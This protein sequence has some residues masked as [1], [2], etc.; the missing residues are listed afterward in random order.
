MRRATPQRRR[1]TIGRLGIGVV[2][3]V[4]TVDD[5]NFNQYSY[6]AHSDAATELGA[7][8]SAAWSSEDAAEYASLIQ[9]LRRRRTTTSSSPLASTWPTT[10]S[11][12][13]RP[14]RT[15]GSSASTRRRS[16]STRPAHRTRLRLR[17]RC[18]RLCIPNFVGIQYAGGP[19][20]LS[21]RHRRRDDQ[22]VT[23]LSA[24]S[25]APTWCPL[26]SLIQGY[27]LGAMSVNPD[28]DVS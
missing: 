5:K 12:P 10:P 20:W 15:S 27:E 8:E 25:A 3:D 21:G 9:T 17:G 22:R 7:A 14:I 6:K 1:V 26:S 13:P 2:T 28:I 16:A 19:G 4:G 18:R 11:M 24:P 23:A